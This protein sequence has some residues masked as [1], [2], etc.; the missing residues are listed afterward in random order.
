MKTIHIYKTEN[1]L[2]HA[3]ADFFI[4]AAAQSI[5]EHN[6]FT[7][8]LSG[9]TSPKKLYQLLSSGLYKNKL[10]WRKVYFFFGD[11]RYVP[12]HDSQRNSLMAQQSLFNSLEISKSQIFKVNTTLSP[13]NAATEYY[14]LIKTHFRDKPIQFDLIL[15]GLG[16]DA[17]TASLFPFTPVLAE[18]KAT[19]I[20][21]FVKE[22]NQYRISMS[23]PL[24]NQAK[25][26]A[27][28]VYGKDKA[29]AAYEVLKGSTNKNQ[30]PAQLIKPVHGKMHWFL[31]E[32]AASLFTELN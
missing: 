27:F 4:E 3:I 12:V 23:A 6:Q 30:F 5:S 20:S 1:E 10:D 2:L 15:L 32:Q 9:G 17:H 29:T 16:D 8:A 25:Q 19:V 18:T 7:V 26:I 22:Q 14:E 21:V 31:D 11:E 24:I 13:Q 28:L